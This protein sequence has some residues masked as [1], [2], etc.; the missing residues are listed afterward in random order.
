MQASCGAPWKAPRWGRSASRGAHKRWRRTVRAAVRALKEVP[1]PAPGAGGG[2]KVGGGDGG[3]G[4]RVACRDGARL[5]ARR[6]VGEGGLGPSGGGNSGRWCVAPGRRKGTARIRRGSPGRT[7]TL[8]RPL[9]WPLRRGGDVR[10]FP[11][12]GRGERQN[13]RGF[14]RA[15]VLTLCHCDEGSRCAP[16]TCTR[17]ARWRRAEIVFIVSPSRGDLGDMGVGQIKAERT[18]CS[19][20]TR[21]APQE[22]CAR[23]PGP[24]KV[25]RPPSQQQDPRLP[26]QQITALYRRGLG[27]LSD[28]L[29][30][31]PARAM[32]FATR[33]ARFLNLVGNGQPVF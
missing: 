21:P 2:Q 10:D 33:P 28:P 30:P 18:K 23:R 20:S 13:P 24:N 8:R 3:V 29:R 19:Y 15:E 22:P 17:S 25:V 27:S 4:G 12:C 1:G 9:R 14:P 6:G 31:L 11:K 16:G 26:G 7:S 32:G 5:R